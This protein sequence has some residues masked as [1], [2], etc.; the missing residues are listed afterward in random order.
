MKRRE[1]RRRSEIAEATV[2]NRRRITRPFYPASRAK[3]RLGHGERAH[4]LGTACPPGIGVVSRTCST[5][6]A[7]AV[8][9]S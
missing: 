4:A 9:V 8:E 6:I 2:N 7:G 5:G 1:P 3:R